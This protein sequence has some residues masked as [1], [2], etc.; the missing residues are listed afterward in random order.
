MKSL[1][2]DGVILVID[3]I[4]DFLEPGA[5]FVIDEGRD[6]Y[7]DMLELIE[8]GRRH[9]MPIVYAAS[10]G[11]TNSMLDRFWWQIRDGV[12]LIPGSEGVEVVDALRPATYSDQEV[13]LPKWKYSCFTGTKLDI[14]LANKPF[15]GRRSMIV[16]GMATN[17]CC[18][19]TTIDAFNRDYEVYLVDDL[20]CT[21]DGID[22]TPATEMHRRT[23][24]T[25]KQGYVAEVLTSSELMSKL[26]AAKGTALEDA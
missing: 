12:S 14:L 16:T 19:C 4:R 11:M 2:E 3:M 17:F 22:G 13:Y 8:F 18:Q 5:K 23:V 15:A 1:V 6:M 7:P 20:N 24:E 25:L 26:E 10:Q 21:F 9:G